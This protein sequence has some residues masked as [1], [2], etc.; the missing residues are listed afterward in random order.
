MTASPFSGITASDI[1]Q[2]DLIVARP[3][4]PLPE[5][6]HMLMQSHITGMPVVSDGRLVGIV[7]RSDLVRMHELV[8]AFDAQVA[9]NETWT[10]AQADGFQHPAPQGFHGFQQRLARLQVRDAM[11]T[12]VVTCK[13]DTPVET[14]AAEMV[15][16]HVH[17]IVVV[18][19]DG[20]KP[21]GIVSSLDLA[22]LLAGLKSKRK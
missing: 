3:E 4:Q 14:I 15:K 1:M 10:D 22:A 20:Q 16:Q 2:G 9:D 17:R 7:S 11:R 8:E 12:Q 6:R 5:V 19:G 18:D 21:V 13:P